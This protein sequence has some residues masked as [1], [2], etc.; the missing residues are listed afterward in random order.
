MSEEEKK[1]A[2][3]VSST[4]DTAHLVA[5]GLLSVVPGAAELLQ[6]LLTPPLEKRRQKWMEEVGQ[7]LRNLENNRG[8]NLEELQSN[9]T[10][11]DTVLQATQIAIRNSQEQKREALRNAVTNCALPNP[12]QQSLQQMFLNYVDL[13]TVWHLL[14]LDLFQDPQEWARRNNHH[15]PDNQ[16]TSSLSSIL[17]NAFPELGKDRTLYDQ[18]WNDLYSR[19]LVNTEGLHTMMTPQG[20]MARRVTEFGAK[21]I[22]FIKA[23]PP[24]N[25]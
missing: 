15:F 12:P 8:V 1:Y 19:G 5:S 13:F 9:E 16:L 11:V 23:P 18:I 22:R 10:F 7:V 2:P 17:A 24:S 25:A 20:A 21:F 14:L 3:P 6:Y 4:G